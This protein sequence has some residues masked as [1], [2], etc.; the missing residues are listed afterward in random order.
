ME[1]LKEI[2]SENLIKLRKQKKWTQLEF[3]EKLNYSNKAVSR[4]EKGEVL[5]DVET[6]AQIADIYDIELAELLKKQTSAKVESTRNKEAIKG[7]KVTITFLAILSVW[8]VGTT[9]FVIH[10]IVAGSS[11]WQIFVWAVPASFL[12][13]T[14]FSS[15]W[16]KTPVTITMISFLMWTVLTGFY[17]QFLDY[18]LWV[19]FIVG[20]PIQICL[21]L[22]GKLYSLHRKRANQ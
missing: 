18:N 1:N 3:A 8:V 16:A 6:L 4:W 12:V 15:I 2:V 22:W 14:I 13:A 11:F 9:F 17:V 10:N 5:P 21:L 20:V 19:L 7:T